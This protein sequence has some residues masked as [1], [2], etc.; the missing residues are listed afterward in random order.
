MPIA[1]ARTALFRV[2]FG[3]NRRS[4]LIFQR[5]ESAQRWLLG[6]GVDERTD[7]RSNLEHA[8]DRELTDGD[9]VCPGSRVERYLLER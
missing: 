8:S 3:E 5:W 2:Y 7:E 9:P 1:E 6:R 4:E